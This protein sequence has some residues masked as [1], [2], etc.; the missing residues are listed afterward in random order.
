MKKLLRNLSLISLL[1]ISCFAFVVSAYA[2]EGPDTLPK[3]KDIKNIVLI[4][5][6]GETAEEGVYFPKGTKLSKI[7]VSKKAI[8]VK[9]TTI[10][11]LPYLS[12]KAKKAV[13][14]KLSFTAA[15]KGKKQNYKVTVTAVKYKNPFK[16]FKI[17]KT[18]YAKKFNK[19]TTTFY[20]KKGVSGKL[21][22]KMNKGFKLDKLWLFEKV[23]KNNSKITL[24]EGSMISV[25]YFN[26]KLPKNNNVEGFFTAL[27]VLDGEKEDEDDE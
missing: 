3:K 13:K 14:G 20:L 12:I 15:F 23:I 4:V 19:D 1:L 2:D 18:D 7:K 6:K 21:S 9:K 17:G 8:K 25:S 26:K 16:S 11:G 24:D 22:I 10:D 27:E 5:H